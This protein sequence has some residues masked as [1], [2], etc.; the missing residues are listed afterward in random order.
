ME[1]W[2]LLLSISLLLSHPHDPLLKDTGVEEGWMGFY[3]GVQVRW[4]WWRLRH[5]WYETSSKAHPGWAGGIPLRYLVDHLPWLII[6]SPIISSSTGEPMLPV[7]AIVP[8]HKWETDLEEYQ[9]TRVGKTF[10]W[11]LPHPQ[12][13]QGGTALQQLHV[14]HEQ[15]NSVGFMGLSVCFPAVA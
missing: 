6:C 5:S 15:G 7:W 14:P 11:E 4:R 1:G 8:F 3:C 2:W 12:F 9:S 13:T 10:R